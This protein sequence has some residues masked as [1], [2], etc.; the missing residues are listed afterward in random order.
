MAPGVN[1]HRRQR[2]FAVD[3]GRLDIYYNLGN[4]DI[5]T[6]A[7]TALLDVKTAGG[8][9]HITIPNGYQ[10]H[11]TNGIRIFNHGATGTQTLWLNNLVSE[12]DGGTNGIYL[13]GNVGI[14]TTTP[15]VPWKCK[16][17]QPPRAPGK[18]SPSSA[19]PELP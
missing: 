5:G 12:L 18:I 19:K 3:D 10:I 15:A 4:V 11:A 14:G 1:C 17:E 13:N 9:E 16:A 7:P 8:G 2:R 6:A